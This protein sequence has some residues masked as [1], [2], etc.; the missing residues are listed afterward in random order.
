MNMQKFIHGGHFSL[1]L[2]SANKAS[3]KDD[4]LTDAG[5]PSAGPCSKP[6]Y[7]IAWLARKRKK[8]YGCQVWPRDL[9]KG[10]LS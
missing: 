5:I 8:D 7:N 2:L 1:L 10:H 6:F 3:L 9:R 4:D